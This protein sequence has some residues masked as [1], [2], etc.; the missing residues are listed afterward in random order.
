VTSTGNQTV[1]TTGVKH[2]ADEK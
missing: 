1:K 2:T